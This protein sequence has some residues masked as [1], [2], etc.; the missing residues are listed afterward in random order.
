MWYER[1]FHLQIYEVRV[2]CSHWHCSDGEGV[3]GAF[4]GLWEA[5]YEGRVHF[6]YSFAE[7]E[8]LLDTVRLP[9]VS[10][11]MIRLPKGAECYFQMI[12]GTDYPF[13][14]L[15]ANC[16]QVLISFSVFIALPCKNPS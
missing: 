13:L 15:C 8:Q 9:K 3:L 10:Q 7:L 1:S 16:T 2:C 5:T 14:S 12:S 11:V 6:P 4:S